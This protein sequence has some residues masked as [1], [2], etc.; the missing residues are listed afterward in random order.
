MADELHRIARIEIDE[1]SL[2]AT[3]ADAEHERR[4]AMF[5]ILE[6]NSFRLTGGKPGP[7]D[8]KLAGADGRLVLDADWA[9]KSI[10]IEPD[11]ALTVPEASVQGL[12]EEGSRVLAGN[13]VLRAERVAAGLKPIP[14]DGE[15]VVGAVSA[16]DGL[17]TLFTHSGATLGLILGELVAEEVLTGRPSP[18][19]DAF[20]LDR[21]EAGA[22]LGEVGIGAW[23]PVTQ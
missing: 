7:Y 16:I 21:F 15:P 5:D 8:L 18:V 22:E 17:Y 14:G 6:A 4:V 20:R 9:E 23:A 13:P 10:V 11:G 2:A 19:L 3:T 12:L 1:A